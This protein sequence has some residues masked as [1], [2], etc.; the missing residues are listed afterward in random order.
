MSRHRNGF[1]N[2]GNSLRTSDAYMRQETGKVLTRITHI[3]VSKLTIIGPD[4]GL[5]PG[6]VF[7]G[8]KISINQKSQCQAI[9]WINVGILLIST[10]GANFS[11]MLSK[12]NTFSSKKMHLKMSSAT[13]RQSVSASMC[14]YEDIS[15]ALVNHLELCSLVRKNVF[16]VMNR[17]KPI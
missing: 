3:Y 13:W 9:I 6:L 10:W 11:E 7:V 16:K 4:N 2:H 1:A 12:I 8:N 15:R 5:L 17:Q 14:Y